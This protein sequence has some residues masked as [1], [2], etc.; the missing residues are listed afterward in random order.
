MLGLLKLALEKALIIQEN[1]MLT[2][3]E[4]FKKRKNRKQELVDQNLKILEDK[5]NQANENTG[6]TF[7][8][9]SLDD[10]NEEQESMT[11]TLDKLKELGYRVH[12]T[13]ELLILSWGQSAKKKSQADQVMEALDDGL[14]KD[15]ENEDDDVDDNYDDDEDDSSLT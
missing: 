13:D 4:A 3:E 14:P 6:E 15:E 12:L 7:V 1:K 10:L 5:V 8:H 11:A 9:I 2:A